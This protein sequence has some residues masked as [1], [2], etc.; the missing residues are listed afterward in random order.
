MGLLESQLPWFLRQEDSTYSFCREAPF[1]TRCSACSLFCVGHQILGSDPFLP[2]ALHIHL[3]A[4]P[5]SSCPLGPIQIKSKNRLITTTSR[6]PFSH[7][8]GI[9]GIYVPRSL[10]GIGDQIAV[11]KPSFPWNALFLKSH[12][13]M[14]G[15]E[16][17]KTL[18]IYMRV[19]APLLQ[20]QRLGQMQKPLGL[21]LGKCEGPGPSPS[22][23][24]QPCL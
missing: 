12:S 2:S 16:I 10:P 8:Q 3:S 11:I 1:A 9:P 5:A 7:L 6:K 21:L 15:Q 20:A 23:L 18:L 22:L 13:K 19:L 17:R 24:A 4:S 14:G